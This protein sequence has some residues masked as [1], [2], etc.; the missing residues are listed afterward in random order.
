M[1]LA[2]RTLPSVGYMCPSGEPFDYLHRRCSVGHSRSRFDDA[3]PAHHNTCSL[4][5]VDSL[6][7]LSPGESGQTND[8][9]IAGGMTAASLPECRVSYS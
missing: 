4:G 3:S 8:L 6:Q 1:R 7:S 5:L 9:A 2:V